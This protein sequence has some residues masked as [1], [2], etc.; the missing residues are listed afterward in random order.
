M[1]R[2][3]GRIIIIPIAFV[4]SALVA[5]FILFTLGLERL[6]HVTGGQLVDF[7]NL[8]QTFLIW[9][10]AIQAL[11]IVSGLT[12]APALLAILVGELARIRS[13]IYYIVAGGLAIIAIPLL[14]GVA[15]PDATNQ[16]IP[17]A[18]PVFATAGFAAGGVYWLLAGRS[19]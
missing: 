19:A 18:W 10:Q 9:D 4:I 3:I 7:E 11:S 12:I 13:A 14:A 16:L 15:A 17:A 1:W 8:G 5:I 6:T 2:A